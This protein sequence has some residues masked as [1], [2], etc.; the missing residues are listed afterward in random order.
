MIHGPSGFFCWT[1]ALQQTALS[2]PVKE[3]LMNALV[4]ASE[5]RH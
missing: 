3:T 1:T 4:I 2:D 5:A